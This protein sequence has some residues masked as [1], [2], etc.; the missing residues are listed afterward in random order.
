MLDVLVAEPPTVPAHGEADVGARVAGARVLG[1]EGPDGVSA[2]DADGHCVSVEC[3]RVFYFSLF[4]SLPV[5][6][7]LPPW[8]PPRLSRIRRVY[9]SLLRVRVKIQFDSMLGY[10][11]SRPPLISC[12]LNR[13]SRKSISQAPSC[14][15]VAT[16]FLPCCPS[17][18]I[19]A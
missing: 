6:F 2:L 14:H 17:S 9:S 4:F 1:P 13:C 7:L 15:L 11:A 8:F 3:A 16:L 10:F 12:R 18:A 19:G 5:L